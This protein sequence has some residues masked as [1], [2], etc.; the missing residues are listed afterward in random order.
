MIRS[1]TAVA[2]LIALCA[3]SACAIQTD[4]S[5]RDVPTGERALGPVDPVDPEAGASEGRSRIFLLT[6]DENSGERLLRSRSREVGSSPDAVLE[7]LFK[8]P[9]QQELEDGLRTE[10]PEELTL[11][12]PSRPIAGTLNVDLSPEIL[13]LGLSQLRLAV[14][15]IVF[16]ASELPGVEDVRLRVDGENR[17]WPD[18]RGELESA[19]LSRYDYPGLVESTQPPF[20]A[21]PSAE[22]P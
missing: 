16:T 5:P 2:G 8:G 12:A 14:A 10:L 3:V 13:E 20:P 21:V 11:N 17:P 1:T 18:G 22:A 9:N 6:S 19:P 15:Q 4:S 7:E